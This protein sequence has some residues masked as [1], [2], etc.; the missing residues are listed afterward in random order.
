VNET[1]GLWL[2]EG[3]FPE[4]LEFHGDAVL[5]LVQPGLYRKGR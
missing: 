2:V 1:S 4:T 5:E 3:L